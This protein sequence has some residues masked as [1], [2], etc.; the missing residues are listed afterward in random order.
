MTGMIYFPITGSTKPADVYG[1][2]RMVPLGTSGWGVL[3]WI[4]RA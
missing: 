3:T 1:Y 2:V 4:R